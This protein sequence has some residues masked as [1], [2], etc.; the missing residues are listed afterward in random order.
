MTSPRRRRT[1]AIFTMALIAGCAAP[2]PPDRIGNRALAPGMQQVCHDHVDDFGDK[3][4]PAS[5][6]EWRSYASPQ[7]S[8]VVVNF[9][10]T[11]FG[12]PPVPGGRGALEW[13]PEEGVVYA[14]FSSDKG[15]NWVRCAQP[16]AGMK[17]VLLVSRMGAAAR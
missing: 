16:P 12:T 10:Q 17:T 5:S 9:Y 15:A 7:P 3:N 13:R 2:G 14:I 11:Q 1:G 8:G 4:R 6:I